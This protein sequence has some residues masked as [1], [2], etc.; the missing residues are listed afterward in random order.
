MV[1]SPCLE[2]VIVIAQTSRTLAF[3]FQSPTIV[4]GNTLVAI[5]SDKCA[6]F[7]ALQSR[8]HQ[9]WALTFAAKLKDDARYIPTDCYE[10]FPFP[11]DYGSDSNLDRVG[12]DYYEFRAAL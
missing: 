1:Q 8:V 6:V 3:V 2:R 4:F 7:A 5:T 12:R 10:T 11:Q 9:E